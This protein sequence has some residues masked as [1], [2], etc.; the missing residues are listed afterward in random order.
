MS[1]AR[2]MLLFIRHA[3]AECMLLG[4]PV[5]C[6]SYDARLSAEGQRQVHSLRSRLNR[7]APLDAAYVSPLRRAVETASAIPKPLHDQM[8]ILRS[9]TEIHCGDVDGM[10]ISEVQQRYPELWQENDAQQNENFSWPGGETYRDFRRRVLRAVKAIARRHEG[11]RV[12]VVTHAGVIN[13]VLGTIRGQSPAQ[14]ES[15]RPRNASITGVHWGRNGAT[16]EFFDDCRHLE[17]RGAT[18]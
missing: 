10:P 5:L 17:E 13:Q 16:V 4:R 9:L 11:H 15:P 14:W 18:G 8:R 3:S 2:A 7:E 6:G 1:H 12:L